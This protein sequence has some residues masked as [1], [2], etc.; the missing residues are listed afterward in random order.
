M[1]RA[2]EERRLRRRN[3]TPTP[4]PKVA[5]PQVAVIITSKDR[6][7][8]LGLALRSVQLQDFIEWECIVVDDASLDDA[9][10]VAQS[11]ATIDSRFS[12]LAH[13]FTRGLSAARNTGIGLAHAPL[14]CFLGDGDLLLAGALRSRIGALDGQPA[15]VAGAYCDWIG[16]DSAARLEACSRPH[17]A[18]SRDNVA[19]ADLVGGAPFV[20]E[21]AVVRVAALQAVGGFDENL[22]AD[23]LDVW[24]RFTRG[25]FRLVYSRSVG[26]GLRPSSAGTLVTEP[27][28]TQLESAP[29]SR[30]GVVG[31]FDTRDRHRRARRIRSP[32]VAQTELAK[33]FDGSVILV[34]EAAYHVDE[35]GPLH[36][37]LVSRGV[38]VRFMA[39]ARQLESTTMALG[40]YADE[41]LPFEPELVVR[42]AGL[43]V[44]NDWARSRPAL[45]A[46]NDAGVPTFAKVE[47]VQ[48]FDDA[49]TGQQRY[50]YLAALVVL[51]QGQN[52]FDALP[53]RQVRIVGST[54]LERIWRAP[55]ASLGRHAL[56]NLNFTYRVLENHRRAWLKS[57]EAG[58]RQAAIEAILSR[59]PAERAA[60]SRLP[61]DVE[62]VPVRNQ[63]RRRSRLAVLYRAVRGDGTWRAVRLPQPA[64][65]TSPDVCRAT[66]RLPDQPVGRR[67]RRCAQDS[68]DLANRLPRA[69]REVLSA[70]GRHRRLP[71]I[72]S[73]C[74][75]RDRR[76]DRPCLVIGTIESAGRCRPY[77]AGPE[78]GS[79]GA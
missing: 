43:V 24:L 77:S 41:I 53:E 14:V 37:V 17:E 79:P 28:A 9:V 31:N 20:S 5:H 48:D 35:L 29:S 49:D 52:D 42:A 78:P 56:V 62:A 51:G 1:H 71:S 34:A 74:C 46:C 75:G 44:L 18:R 73:P 63:P 60:K 72:R 7:E 59:H 2:R 65:R 76:G 25:G 40:R 57:V 47:G 32:V 23:D 30:V 58:V 3:E 19:F 27:P 68:I 21:S 15:N 54:R 67:A 16:L 4:G 8:L 39:G 50:P 45:D 70:A 61:T 33:S 64:R 12:V 13:D 11:F 69:S 6:S 38:K 36:D 10:A 66:W 55:P 26:I 22:S